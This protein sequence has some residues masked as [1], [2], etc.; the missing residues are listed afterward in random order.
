MLGKTHMAVGIAATLTIT[1]PQTIPEIILAAG[2]GAVGA[3]I[4]DIDIETSESHKN[5]N[6]ITL[7]AVASLCMVC[8]LDFYH[9]AG[10]IRQILTSRNLLRV[11]LGA[12]VFIAT[13]TFG[14]EQPHR[15]FMH[16]FLALGIL[17]FA[18]G[19]ITP[20]LV[21]YFAVGFLSHLAMDILNKKKVRLFFPLK[22][23]FCLGFFHAQGFMN[24]ALFVVGCVVSIVET[25]VLGFFR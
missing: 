16:S 19:M 22:G 2:T 15:S 14:K 18:V 10:I 25:A 8:F 5:A 7:L 12:L 9:N 11:T 24:S 23:G 6:K 4:S 17:S 1:K 13:C 20:V 3:L 21:P